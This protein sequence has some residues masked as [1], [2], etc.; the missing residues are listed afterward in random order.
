[1]T[2]VDGAPFLGSDGGD[3]EGDYVDKFDAASPLEDFE[4]LAIAAPS[5]KEPEKP[6]C[7]T[8]GTVCK[9]GICRDYRNQLKRI[10]REKNGEGRGGHNGNKR[11]GSSRGS[12]FSF[13]GRW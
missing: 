10:E 8:H 4:S 6:V 2:M 12:S 1:M 9:K 3:T 11:G 7:I 5:T 13:R